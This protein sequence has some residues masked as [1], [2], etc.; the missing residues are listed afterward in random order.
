MLNAS[1]TVL[2]LG[3]LQCLTLSS[4]PVKVN[5]SR[6][7]I[8][9]GGLLDMHCADDVIKN[10]VLSV[11]GPFSTD[12][13]VEEFEKRKRFGSFLGIVLRLIASLSGWC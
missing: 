3:Q 2:F 4:S 5:P 12:E 7:P 1:G 11:K 9:A 10:L 13:L 6:L 8:V